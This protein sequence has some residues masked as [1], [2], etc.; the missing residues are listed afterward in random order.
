[1]VEVAPAAD[2]ENTVMAT[3]TDQIRV[4]LC[5]DVQAFRALMRFALEEDEGITVVGEAADGR[6]GIEGVA[7]LQPDVVLLD[8]S[9]PVCDGL[10]AIP[11]MLE[12]SP[13]SK[14]IALSGFTAERMAGPML[15][16]G[17]SAYLEKG[18]DLDVIQRTVR[19]VAERRASD[20]AA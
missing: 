6:A 2:D 20:V 13:R 9:M 7:A 14:V 3:A 11:Q 16:Q 15:E 12:R 18:A 1:M 5:D 19:E 4:F 17:A 8:L 10:E